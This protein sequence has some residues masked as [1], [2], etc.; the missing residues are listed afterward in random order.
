MPSFS[1]KQLL[2]LKLSSIKRENLKELADNSRYT[3]FG[4]PFS[5]V[6]NGMCYDTATASAFYLF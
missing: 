1:H 4:K 6:L 2:N 3:A 5:H